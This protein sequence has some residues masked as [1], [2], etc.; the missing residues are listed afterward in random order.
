MNI[1]P[2]KVGA[3]ACEALSVIL[4]TGEEW[5]MALQSSLTCALGLPSINSEVI[6]TLNP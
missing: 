2:D 6:L 4:V 5:N 1:Q 3:A